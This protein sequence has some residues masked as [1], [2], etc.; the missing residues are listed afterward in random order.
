MAAPDVMNADMFSPHRPIPVSTLMTASLTVGS[1]ERA[2]R[3]RCGS[4][5]RCVASTAICEASHSLASAS[6]AFARS[7]SCGAVIAWM[8]GLSS[9]SCTI[10]IRFASCIARAA[11][12]A[13]AC[14]QNSWLAVR[15]AGW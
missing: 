15:S 12:S 8:I 3:S 5:P 14:S 13:I 11:R 1:V 2:A 10:F 4:T 9:P 7:R 6:S